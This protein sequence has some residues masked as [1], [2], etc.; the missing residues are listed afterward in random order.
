MIRFGLAIYSYI[1]YSHE[2]NKSFRTGMEDFKDLIL[3]APVISLQQQLGRGAYGRVYEVEYSGKTCAAKEIHPIL[4]TGVRREEAQR[5]IN[6]FLRE[7]LQC[8]KLGHPNIVQ[9][10]GVYYPPD[11]TGDGTAKY[12]Y[13]DAESIR[14]PVMVMEKMAKSLASFMN[15]QDKVAIAR[16]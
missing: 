7:C 13:M 14:V 11:D 12:S 10:F 4:I 1:G 8:R 15:T 2:D 5:T 6:S 3:Q 9:F 16:Y